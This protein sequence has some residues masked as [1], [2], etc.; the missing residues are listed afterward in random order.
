MKKTF[1]LVTA[2]ICC[3]ILWWYT[4][5]VAHDS[6]ISQLFVKES[7]VYRNFSKFHNIFGTDEFLVLAVS[8]KGK[9][10]LNDIS[11]N[12]VDKLTKRFAKDK[13]IE[14]VVSITN[15]KDFAVKKISIPF[16]DDKYVPYPAG[17]LLSPDKIDAKVRQRIFSDPFFY[18][19]LISPDRKTT[20]IWLLLKPQLKER[21][22]FAAYIGNL[23]QQVPTQVR[24]SGFPLIY[25]VMKQ[26]AMRDAQ[27]LFS[28]SFLLSVTLLIICKVPLLAIVG[29]FMS[30]LVTGSLW[31]LFV[32]FSGSGF[33]V[34]SN[35]VPLFFFITSVPVVIHMNHT[36][37]QR[38]KITRRACFWS[39]ITTVV[40]LFTLYFSNIQP[41]SLLGIEI[42][43]VMLTSFAVNICFC[44]AKESVSTTF[45]AKNNRK[46][47]L[48]AA[49]FLS[50]PWIFL[51]KAPKVLPSFIDYLPEEHKVV[52]DFRY[53][54]QKLKAQHPL[55]IM[56][57]FKDDGTL[58]KAENYLHLQ[59]LE[60]EMKE[61]NHE[62]IAETI[63]PATLMA[64]LNWKFE[65]DTNQD[66][67][68]EN[69]RVV[70]KTTD[71]AISWLVKPFLLFFEGNASEKKGDDILSYY[72]SQMQ[73]LFSTDGKYT[74]IGCRLRSDD[75]LKILA[76]ERNLQ[77]T[78]DKYAR[79]LNAKMYCT[80]YSLLLANTAT[81]IYETQYISILWGSLF[82]AILFW[83]IIRSWRLTV[84]A[85]FVN[86]M[87]LF[88]V[89]SV[90]V[91]CGFEITLYTVVLL[92]G[93]IGIMVDDTIHFMVHYNYY[94]KYEENFDNRV[95]KTLQQVKPAIISSSLILIGG[96][97]VFFMSQLRVY[98]SFGFIFQT[99]ILL[100]LFWDCY[101]L[102]TFMHI[103][104]KK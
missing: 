59:N 3:V 85:V 20:F 68:A 67:R 10:I 48:V 9:D 21:R 75:P 43:L 6:S 19:G 95:A 63:S 5:K 32:Y 49:V 103:M 84:L 12:M 73:Q 38:Q 81:N 101:A 65:Y 22:D 78:L 58:L 83:V 79:L 34:F 33:H 28:V 45:V 11:V 56:I 60:R 64:S 77:K 98:H 31:V 52:R 40:G 51:G 94:C 42:P 2:A 72:R 18:T 29:F 15:I 92:A 69:F 39:T 55:E 23:Q 14:M 54:S 74:R 50:L 87:S 100:A 7:R 76:L 26:L 70:A 46:I 30:L 44:T 99:G 86:M 61:N 25:I 35:I 41:I 71:F 88:G 8:A 96:F 93:L 104:C 36:T 47:I 102:P 53:I 66:A 62:M 90:F 37:A 57:E 97:S 89:V 91:L 27:I 16:F 24:I 13:N 4:P 80:G 1:C 82:I 17:N